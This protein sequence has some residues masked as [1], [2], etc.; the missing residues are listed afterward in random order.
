MATFLFDK[1]IFGP[2]KSRRLGVSLGINLLPVDRKICSFDCIY[3]ECGLNVKGGEK[4]PLPSRAEVRSLLEQKLNEMSQEKLLPD[5]ITFAG[6]GEPTLHPHFA[7]II[8]DTIELRNRF[9]PFARIAVLSNST[10][11]DKDD[12]REALLK[13]DDNI[14][15]LDSGLDATIQLLDK[16][17]GRFHLDKLMLGLKSFNGN[18]TIQTMFVRGTVDEIYVDNTSKADVNSWLN[19]L[20]E[21]K[22]R[23]VM[24]YTIE[25]D[26]PFDG[27]TKV[28]LD[29]LN[30]IAD[31]V[32]EIGF[33]VQVSG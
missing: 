31:R 11:I 20:Q 33:D 12:I 23:Q 29:E 32:R 13:V 2:V 17:E 10:R 15:K 26:T 3:C 27:L 5:V 28:P 30:A 9:C 25:R 16:P 14:L 8:D 21:I 19:C 1:T 18:L 22:P 6:N 24:I 4:K 7:G